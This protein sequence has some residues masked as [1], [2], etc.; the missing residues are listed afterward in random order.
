MGAMV[1]LLHC[2]RLSK[3][4]QLKLYIFDF[5]IF[6]NAGDA[7]HVLID[8]SPKSCL[9]DELQ[10]TVCVGAGVLSNGIIRPSC[11]ALEWLAEELSRVGAVD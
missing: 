1:L 11:T 4:A 6:F 9:Q 7:W 10:C 5:L 2:G 3:R 8:S